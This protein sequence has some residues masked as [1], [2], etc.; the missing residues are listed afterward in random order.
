MVH[1]TF[2]NFADVLLE[3]VDYFGNPR[4]RRG[5]AIKTDTGGTAYPSHDRFLLF[6]LSFFFLL[7]SFVF[8]FF[9][10]FTLMDLLIICRFYNLTF[11]NVSHNVWF[12]TEHGPM[13]QKSQ[14]GILLL[15]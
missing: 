14:C 1:T 12:N 6:F 15:F 3:G 5:W 9:R 11:Y 10:Y 2:Q 4:Q 7:S 13:D 8:L